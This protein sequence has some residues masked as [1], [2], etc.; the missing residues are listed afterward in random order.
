MRLRGLKHAST[1][2]ATPMKDAV[3]PG[4]IYEDNAV[5]CAGINGIKNRHN[6]VRDTLVDICYRSGISTGNEVDIGLDGTSSEY[7]TLLL[8]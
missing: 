2:L 4:D 7:I 3:F 6:V 5:S 1:V 8:G